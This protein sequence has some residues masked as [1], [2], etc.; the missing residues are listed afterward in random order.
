MKEWLKAV[1]ALLT[2]IS[3]NPESTVVILPLEIICSI[4][5]S[6]ISSSSAASSFCYIPCRAETLLPASGNCQHFRR[7]G[8]AC[9]S[10]NPFCSPCSYQLCGS[11]TYP[12][13]ELFH[14]SVFLPIDKPGTN[15]SWFILQQMH[16]GMW[17]INGSICA[18]SLPG[19][20]GARAVA[21]VGS[22][23]PRTCL[24]PSATLD[25]TGLFG[26]KT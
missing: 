16:R 1:L 22:S 26:F 11:R 12:F 17:V 18:R 15:D 7:S 19:C 21:H 24:N 25:C 13:M 23:S 9:L 6:H 8:R 3:L 2:C 4:H 14:C 20:A 10:C 5:Q